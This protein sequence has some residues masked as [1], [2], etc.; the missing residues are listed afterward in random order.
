MNQLPIQSFISVA[1]RRTLISHSPSPS[2]K[3][4]CAKRRAMASVDSSF[5]KTHLVNPC[6]NFR[7][8]WVYD[9]Q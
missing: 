3:V 1:R 5:K 7:L 8:F 6:R 9:R 2:R 4:I